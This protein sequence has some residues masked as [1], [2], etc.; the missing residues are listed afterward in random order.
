MFSR[1]YWHKISLIV[2]KRKLVGLR[3]WSSLYSSRITFVLRTLKQEFG[4]WR[5]ISSANKVV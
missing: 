1:S 5:L 3:Q 2:V 4:I